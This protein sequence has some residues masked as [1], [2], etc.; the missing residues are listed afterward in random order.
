VNDGDSTFNDFLELRARVVS[1]FIQST[2]MTITRVVSTVE[3][4][5]TQSVRG[6]AKQGG[7]RIRE[8]SVG[9]STPIR[10][11]NH[12]QARTKAKNY[13]VPDLDPELS[14]MDLAGARN[15]RRG[16]PKRE[17]PKIIPQLE[18]FFL[19]F[20]EFGACMDRSY[21]VSRN[22]RPRNVWS[23]AA[24]TSRRCIIDSISTS[25]YEHI[26]IR[27]DRNGFGHN[28]WAITQM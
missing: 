24:H 12:F 10:L 21:L 4:C 1:F 11:L 9:L 17:G 22:P 5:P 20:I 28:G 23:M 7:I 2:N 19:L 6:L 18:T 26:C 27:L 13:P 14:Q 15:L 3:S 25:R 8:R 16:P